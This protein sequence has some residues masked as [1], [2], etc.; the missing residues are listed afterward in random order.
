MK[1]FFSILAALCLLVVAP[2]CDPR[3]HSHDH[4]E[5]HDH[6]E[7]HDHGHSPDEDHSH[8][9]GHSHDDEHSRE[10]GHAHE[11]AHAHGAT[12]GRPT[13]A[14]TKWTDLTELFMEYPAF[15]AGERGRSAI[16]VTKLADFSPLDDGEVVV[17]L[18]S[19]AGE[20]LDFRGG[21]SQPGIFGIDLQVDR[22]GFYD[23]RVRVEAPRLT[24]VH[25]LGP[26]RVHA[27]GERVSVEDQHDGGIE[28]LKEQQWTLEFG[29]MAA[30]ARALS[31]SIT[32]PA[33]LDPR[34]GGRARLAAP[35]P[36]RVEAT[37]PVPMPGKR[38]R[39]GQ[40]LVRIVPRS[41]DLRD[42]SALRAALVEAEQSH[43]LALGER[44]RVERLVEGRALP[45]RRRIEAEAALETASARLEA[46]QHRWS[47]YQTL[48]R[49]ENADLAEGVFEVRAPFDG[50]V[51]RVH[52]APGASVDENESLVEIVDAANLHVVGAVP[53]SNAS[54]LNEVAK[55]EI[56]VDEGAPIALTSPVAVGHVV[57][58]PA[59]TTE[60]RF[61][62][63][64]RSA[65]YRVGQSLR[66][67]LFLGGARSEV[68]VPES[69][70]IDDAG[71]PVVFV[72]TGGE[73][74]ERR[75]VTL[76][77][78]A[79]GWVHVLEGIEHGDRVVHEGAY[80]VRL[81]AMST[82]IPAHGHVH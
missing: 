49:A 48:S 58:E 65:R 17:E 27:P 31:S 59:R 73:S 50:V 68:A 80:L 33:V 54:A 76:G 8:G 4:G 26:V 30:T 28:F 71:R 81:A 21:P 15:V 12:E 43:A 20:T 47:R 55:G 46:A 42:A 53:E 63:D 61:A 9:E 2:A 64:N 18:R 5:P 24:D 70:V 34:P 1:R 37:L 7:H 25:E 62:F 35:V 11:G 82:Q 74:F 29:T 22:A 72:Q 75:S 56:V 67:R 13:V 23:M 77:T 32:V 51:S 3:D 38:V 10:D 41:E 39:T 44:K 60:V 14:V 69:A 40:A 6:G 16:H 79:S 52:F 66:L 36:G 78:R 19:E 45:A 57:E